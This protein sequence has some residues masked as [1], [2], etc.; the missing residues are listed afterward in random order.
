MSANI[1]LG[2]SPLRSPDWL[3]LRVMP[4]QSAAEAL[5]AILTALQGIEERAYAI[6]GRALLMIEQRELYKL[7]TDPEIGQPFVSM[8]RW[9]L[10]MHEKHY[11]SYRDALS[12]AKELNE[13]P[14][15]DFALMP[16]ANIKQLEGCSSSIRTK[17]DV[18]EAAKTMPEKQFVKEVLNQKYNQHLEVRQPVVMAESAVSEKIDQAVEM[19]IALYGCKSRGEALEAIAVDF[20]QSHSAEVERLEDEATA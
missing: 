2:H 3:A 5:R 6:R 13:I 15:E 1:A 8:N 10:V 19:A 16:R 9:L 12:A 14:F 11:R 4:E 17:P 18:I 20:L 7:D